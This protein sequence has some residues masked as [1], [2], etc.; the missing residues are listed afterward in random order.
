MPIRMNKWKTV[1]NGEGWPGVSNNRSQG[2]AVQARC[3]GGG[4]EDAAR[5]KTPADRAIAAGRIRRL[6]RPGRPRA[7]AHVCAAG[8]RHHLGTGGG[9]PDLDG[10]AGIQ[11]RTAAALHRHRADR[12]EHRSWSESFRG[13][14]RLAPVRARAAAL[15]PQPRGGDAARSAD[16]LAIPTQ[17]GP[18]VVLRHRPDGVVTGAPEDAA[19][20]VVGSDHQQHLHVVFRLALRGRRRALAAQPQRLGGIRPPVRRAVIRRARRLHRH[21]GSA[22]VGSRALHRSRCRRWPVRPTLHVP[23]LCTRSRRRTAGRDAQ[24]PARRPSVH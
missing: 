4:D 12:R 20:T 13:P 21:A 16:A 1:G 8:G 10:R 6:R 15:R 18:V 23:K 14:A 5:C 3:A 22:A 7:L 17:R 19:T 24:K 2:P 11:S 9:L